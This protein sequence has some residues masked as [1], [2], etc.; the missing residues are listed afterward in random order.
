[1]KRID[2]IRRIEE[3]GATLVREGGRHT[4]YVNPRTK[5]PIVVPRH[6]EIKE[7]LAKKIIRDASK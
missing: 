3:V 4:I 1:M 6:G 7:G 2:L 5:A